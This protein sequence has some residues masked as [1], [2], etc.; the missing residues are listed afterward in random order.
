MNNSIIQGTK[1]EEYKPAVKF[2][3]V[4]AG[5]DINKLNKEQLTR[6]AE[7]KAIKVREARSDKQRYY[8]PTN[9]V[10]DNFHRGVE[11][12]RFI[13]GGNRSG[14]TVTGGMEAVWIA[15]G[16]HPYKKV[17]V[18]NKGWV[19]SL[20]FPSS[21]DIAETEVRRWL[22]SGRIKK[23]SVADRIIQLTNGS[24]I[25][26]KSCDSGREKFQGVSRD[27]IWF[28]EE[29]NE[30]VYQECYMRTIDTGGLIWCTMTPVNGMSWSY[31]EIWEMAGINPDIKCYSVSTLENSYIDKSEIEKS[32]LIMIQDEIDARI[33]GKYVQ[34]S[35]LIYKGFD[36]N[37]HV[38][39]PFDIPRDW[40]KYRTL[41]HGINNPT[42]C[43]WCAVNPAGEM[44]IY[45]EYYETE[46]T[47]RENCENIVQM[48]GGD[49]IQWT[50]I[51]P[52]TNNRQGLER[53]IRDE[54]TKYGLYTK[55]GNND[56]L[57]GINRVRQLLMVNEDT[58]RP[59]L[60]FF[61]T[62]FATLKEMLRYRY[63][64]YKTKEEKNLAEEPIK[65]L[66]HAM[67]ALRYLC[68]SNPVYRLEDDDQP[69]TQVW[70]S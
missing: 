34:F 55:L 59:R 40:K 68:M 16:E 4:L 12:I 36:K 3:E 39:K 9:R 21:R 25:G 10:M 37:V 13:V 60:F 30:S 57:V 48:T 53:S 42:A 54:Y 41:D 58:K 67:D 47:V 31:E 61:D 17:R 23:W 18:P 6:L 46:R 50:T 69:E 52:T 2:E 15:T 64:T 5:L 14:K 70:Y 22:G 32:K 49:K 38:V 33:Y 7:V 24:E 56:K 26:F 29:P 8:K 51:D 20:D 28:D 62:C 43:L 44:Y 35:G 45:D 11:K 1:V 65:A 27:W 66:D 19:V 63:K